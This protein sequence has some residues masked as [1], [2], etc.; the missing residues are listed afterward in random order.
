MA[1]RFKPNRAQRDAHAH[2]MTALESW[3]DG[4]GRELNAERASTGTV[5]FTVAGRRYRVGTHRPGVNYAG[6][7]TFHA[8]PTRTPAIAALL[9]AGARLDGRGN[10]TFPGEQR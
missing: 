3:I 1:Y 10:P 6:E 2:A 8:A 9:I 4:P 5:Y 7:V